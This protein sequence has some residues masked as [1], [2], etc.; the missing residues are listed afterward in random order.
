MDK[1]IKQLLEILINNEVITA[2]QIASIIHLSEKTVRNRL[3]ILD[4]ELKDNVK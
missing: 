1:N 2:S 3:K 4:K